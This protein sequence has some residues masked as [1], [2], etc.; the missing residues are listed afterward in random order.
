MRL[1]SDPDA[2]EGRE[3]PEGSPSLRARHGAGC[4]SPCAG[5]TRS[6]WSEQV[7]RMTPRASCSSACV[8]SPAASHSVQPVF[9]SRVKKPCSANCRAAFAPRCQ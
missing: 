9:I 4:A 1:Q 5:A 8:G 3:A 7:H 2:V 6:A